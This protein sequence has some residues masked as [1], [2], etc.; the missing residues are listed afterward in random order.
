MYAISELRI[1]L[2]TNAL[3][4]SRPECSRKPLERFL[5]FVVNADSVRLSEYCPMSDA[6]LKFVLWG[7]KREVIF[8]GAS[9]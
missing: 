5:M 3:G 7:R 6:V 8:L 9:C 1:E 2:E 4:S